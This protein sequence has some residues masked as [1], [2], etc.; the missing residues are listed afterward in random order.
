MILCLKQFQIPMYS[1]KQRQ[2]FFEGK[3]IEIWP[4][5]L[6]SFTQS[7]LLSVL[8]AYACSGLGTAVIV[9]LPS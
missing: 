6:Q 7:M 2:K 8:I 4:V 5:G 3:L 1:S 9:G